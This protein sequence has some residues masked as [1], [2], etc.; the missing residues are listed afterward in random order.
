MAG[1]YRDGS[2]DAVHKTNRQSA[3]NARGDQHGPLH[4]RCEGQMVPSSGMRLSRESACH[5]RVIIPCLA[6]TFMPTGNTSKH[7]HKDMHMTKPQVT[8]E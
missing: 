4:G 3:G 1:R 7:K 8:H 6:V 5:K 2:V